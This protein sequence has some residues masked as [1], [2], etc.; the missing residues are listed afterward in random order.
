[1]LRLTSFAAA[2]ILL[3]SSVALSSCE[4]AVARRGGDLAVHFPNQR[5]HRLYLVILPL[6]FA[7]L[8]LSLGCGHAGRR[9]SCGYC[10]GFRPL[11][12][13]L[14]L[15]AVLQALGLLLLLLLL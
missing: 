8:T 11:A 1:M 3:A 2:A 7:V 14:G 13:T 9:G 6:A 12:T 4:L 10:R 5:V 15:L